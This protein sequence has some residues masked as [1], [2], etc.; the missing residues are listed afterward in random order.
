[1]RIE[2][3]SEKLQDPELLILTS[4]LQEEKTKMDQQI[5][6]LKTKLECQEFML[7]DMQFMNDE[8]QQQNFLLRS[9]LKI[10]EIELNLQKKDG[11]EVKDL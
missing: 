10:N 1:M 3:E 5:E 6:E 2:D 7:T 4:K 9:T 8:L 11:E